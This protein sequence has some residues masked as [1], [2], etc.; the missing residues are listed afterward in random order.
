MKNKPKK[1]SNTEKVS[2]CPISFVDKITLLIGG[3]IGFGFYCLTGSFTSATSY[4]SSYNAF[5]PSSVRSS[6]TAAA[7]RKKIDEYIQ[8][9]VNYGSFCV[10]I[11][12]KYNFLILDNF[13]DEL[14]KQGYAVVNRDHNLK[15]DGRWLTD[16]DLN[17]TICWQS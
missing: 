4:S 9:A 5:K 7:Q 6:E 8:T 15:T 1:G 3:I 14:F 16:Y 17:T 11:P 10:T 2:S 12:K 13:L